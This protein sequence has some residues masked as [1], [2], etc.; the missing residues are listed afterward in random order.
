MKPTILGVIPARG[1]SKRLP[2]KNILPVAG[3][4]LIAWTIEA[5]KRSK[6]MDTF[7]IS[8]EDTGIKKISEHYGAKVLDR[9][10]E[11]A[12]D[13]STTLEVLQHVLKQYPTDIIVLL[14]CT[15][16]IRSKGLID[17]CIRKF[18][19]SD[20]DCLAT[21]RIINEGEWGTYNTNPGN[22]LNK[23]GKKGYFH[24]DG[25]IYVFKSKI[26]HKNMLYTKNNLRIVSSREESIDINDGFD[27]WVAGQILK[28]RMQ[29]E[30]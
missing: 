29:N 12:K 20:A 18:L 23:T 25:N 17:R 19:A 14:Q 22:Y 5:A 21:G 11:L 26:I 9:P 10:K 8:T 7:I 30:K 1:N 6:L 3:K 13:A 24:D 16:P 15:C 28:E 27:I 4:P 2:R